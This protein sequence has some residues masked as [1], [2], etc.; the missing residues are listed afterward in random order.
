VK[1]PAEAV[2]DVRVAEFCILCSHVLYLV[3]VSLSA[4]RAYGVIVHRFIVPISAI[5]CIDL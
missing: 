5:F 2:I 4:L 1:K 3:C